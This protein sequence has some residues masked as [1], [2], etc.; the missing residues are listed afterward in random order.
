VHTKKQ[1]PKHTHTKERKE[2][3]AGRKEEQ[4][5]VN[6]WLLGEGETVLL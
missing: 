2:G 3:G 5:E 6:V 4:N 1:L